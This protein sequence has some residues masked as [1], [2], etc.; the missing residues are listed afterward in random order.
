MHLRRGVVDCDAAGLLLLL[1]LRIVGGQIGRDALPRFAV[2]ARAEEKL[3][4]DVDGPLLRGAHVDRRV[5]VEPHLPLF[6][7]GE[8]LDGALLVRLAIDAADLSA[9]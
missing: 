3:R 5:P 1:L 2:I 9:L 8:R 4:A 7:I 6:V